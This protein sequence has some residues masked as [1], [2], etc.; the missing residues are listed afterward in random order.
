VIANVEKLPNPVGEWKPL[1]AGMDTNSPILPHVKMSQRLSPDGHNPGEYGAVIV[2]MPTI[3]S[4]FLLSSAKGP[5]SPTD[6]ILPALMVAISFLEAVEGPLWVAVRGKGLAYGSG[7]KRDPDGGFV[8]F[9]VYRSPDAYRAF[10]A[11]K[12]VVESY[13]SGEAKFEQSALEG[14]ISGIVV[15]FAVRSNKFF[16]CSL[17]YI[18]QKIGILGLGSTFQAF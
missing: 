2:P 1:I 10:V 9:S 3:D 15:G 12:T 5:T 11:A 17:R 14:A 4:S 7:F 8:Q 18:Y 16:I 13:I 6:P